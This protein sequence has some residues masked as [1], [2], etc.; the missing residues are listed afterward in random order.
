[1]IIKQKIGKRVKFKKAKFP[2][3][4]KIIGKYSYLEPLRIKK[5]AKDLFSNF[6]NS[7]ANFSIQLFA[8]HHLV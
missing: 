8:Y 1:M 4:K 7:Q 5:H 2:L 6:L 3:N